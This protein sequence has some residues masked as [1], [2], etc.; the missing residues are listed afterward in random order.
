M[1]VKTRPLVW[2]PLDHR[3]LGDGP[4]AIPYFFLGEKYASSL[5]RSA[6]AQPCAFPLAGESD[7]PALLQLLM[8]SYCR[9]PLPT[10]SPIILIRP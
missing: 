10:S 7:I 5:R 3:L 9:V 4:Q 6:G 8:G 1:T 2:L